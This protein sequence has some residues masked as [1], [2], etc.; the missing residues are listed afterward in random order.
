M[1]SCIYGGNSSFSQ[2]SPFELTNLQE[3]QEAM[4]GLPTGIC[5]TS[6]VFPQLHNII[7]IRPT[8]WFAR[9]KLLE[10]RGLFL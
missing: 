2:P 7:S 9:H 5:A 4:L 3:C 10:R 6:A 8:K 1:V